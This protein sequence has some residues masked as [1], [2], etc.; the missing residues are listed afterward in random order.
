MTCTPLSC[1]SLYFL[2]FA[3][4]IFKLNLIAWW[5]S[6]FEKQIP[7]GQNHSYNT[8]Y[9]VN[10]VAPKVLLP[11]GLKEFQRQGLYIGLL[12]RIRIK[13]KKRPGSIFRDFR[14]FP[15]SPCFTPFL[16]CRGSKNVKNAPLVIT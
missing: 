7:N 5:A 13:S 1:A 3:Y 2:F 9:L 15:F 12:F 14:K 6:I 10:L 4:M 11:N 8:S 16:L